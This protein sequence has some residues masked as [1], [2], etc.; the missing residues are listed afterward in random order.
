MIKMDND[1]MKKLKDMLD[2]GVI[3]EDVYNEIISRWDTSGN[4]TEPG[5]EKAGSQQDQTRKRGETLKLSGSSSLSEVFAKEFK[6]SGSSRIQ[7]NCDADHIHISGSARIGGDVISAD[8]MEVSG[9]LRVEGGITGNNISSSGSI[10]AKDI[11]CNDLNSSG[12]LQ[13]SGK[14]LAG[15]ASFS[16]SS[17]ATYMEIDALE[18]SGSVR[19]ENILSGQVII[20]GRISSENVVCRDIE[21]ELYNSAGRIK[22]LE[23]ESIQI[24]LKAKLFSRGEIKIDNIKCTKG[25]FN[26][27]KA[28]KVTG[29]ELHFG[30]NCNIDFAEARKITIEEGSII[31]EKK[32]M[33]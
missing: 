26:G 21:I 25:D 20:H 8:N 31:R 24:T 5:P 13:I 17:E 22:N 23:A 11:Q 1:Q 15:K 10:Y 18:S 19:A 4:V 3:S 7:G 28:T 16:G 6:V 29:E 2:S 33:D 12:S 9:L 32:I 30:S 27:L 14:I